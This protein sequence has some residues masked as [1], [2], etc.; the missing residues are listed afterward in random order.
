MRP[1]FT[2]CCISLHP[3]GID[4]TDLP[5]AAVIRHVVAHYQIV[6]ILRALKCNGTEAVGAPGS[7]SPCHI[8]L[9][10]GSSFTR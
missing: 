2:I 10:P 7:P 6:L 1:L 5:G 4:P 8:K 9:Q 3:R